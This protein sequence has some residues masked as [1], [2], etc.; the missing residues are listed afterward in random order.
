MATEEDQEHERSYFIQLSLRA[1]MSS[2]I[3]EQLSLALQCLGRPAW[4]TRVE[5]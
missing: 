2:R 3:S 1:T 4:R 5:A